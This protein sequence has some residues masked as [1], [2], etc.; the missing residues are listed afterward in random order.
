MDFKSAICKEEKNQLK[1]LADELFFWLRKK[2]FFQS[3]N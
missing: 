1:L 2:K 3:L